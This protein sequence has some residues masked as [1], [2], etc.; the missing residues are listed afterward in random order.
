MAK[1]ISKKTASKVAKKTAS[2]KAPAKKTVKQAAAKPGDASANAGLIAEGKKAPAFSLQDQDG[3]AHKLSDYAGRP[4]VLFFYPKDMTSG[5]TAEACDFRDL[6]PKFDTS[7]AAVFGISIMNTKSKAKFAAKEGLN[8]PLLADDATGEDG[9]P[10]PSVAKKYGVWVEKSMY[11]NTY[12]GI[13]R[14]TYLIGPDGKVAKRWDKVKVPGH[15]AEVL[16]AVRTIAT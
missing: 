3:K 6:L 12:M 1:K 7:K 2:K 4:V 15:A 9:K 16:E 10:A 11:G 5:C 14:T 8:Y 13:E